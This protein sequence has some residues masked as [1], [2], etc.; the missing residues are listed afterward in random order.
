MTIRTAPLVVSPY[1]DFFVFPLA[2]L[3]Q[4]PVAE[5]RLVRRCNRGTAQRNYTFNRLRR[6]NTDRPA[7]IN[8]LLTLSGSG[9]IEPP[10]PRPQSTQTNLRRAERLIREDGQLG[11]AL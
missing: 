10:D 1:L 7:L 4:M 8:E 6:W 11:K 9:M 3:G 5:L 2:V